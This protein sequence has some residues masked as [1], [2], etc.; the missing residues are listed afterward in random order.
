[1][2]LQSI[3]TNKLLPSPKQN[4]FHLKNYPTQAIRGICASSIPNLYQTCKYD[5]SKQK[6]HIT[7]GIYLS[8]DWKDENGGHLEVWDGDS[9]CSKNPKLYKCENKFLPEFNSLIIFTC[10]DYAY[11]GNPNK[12]ICN[13]DEKRLFLT[14]SYVSEKYDDEF[15]NKLEKAYFIKRPEDPEN[16]E[17]DRLRD[18]RCD[19]IK[20]KEIYN[21]NNK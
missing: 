16:K 3:I 9:V 18:L 5:H 19:P 8:K 14:L 6:K 12:T 13:N 20:Y 21:L 15:Q 7:L 4:T 11:H 17:K 1:M 2:F 10:N